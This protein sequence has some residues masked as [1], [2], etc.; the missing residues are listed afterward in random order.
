MH[1]SKQIIMG[2][3]LVSFLDIVLS[4]CFWRKCSSTNGHTITLDNGKEF[5]G[6]KSL[7]QSLNV[8]VYFA[9]PYCSWQRGTNENTNA[10]LRRFFPKGTDFSTITNRQLQTAVDTINHRTRKILNYQTPAELFFR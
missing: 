2:A 8:N 7:Q 10:L 4:K 5:S 9:D 1:Q 3:L 6:F